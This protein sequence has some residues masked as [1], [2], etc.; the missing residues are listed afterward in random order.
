MRNTGETANWTE[1][2]YEWLDICLESLDSPTAPI[3]GIHSL[4]TDELL[5]RSPDDL[6]KLAVTIEAFTLICI[7]LRSRGVSANVWVG[8]PLEWPEENSGDRPFPPPTYEETRKSVASTLQMPEIFVRR[9]DPPSQHAHDD[10]SVVTTN[11][12]AALLN[13]NL[14]DARL[15]H[16]YWPEAEHHFLALD[17]QT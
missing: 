14:E 2:L 8:I 9:H 12:D 4:H 7:A 3:I 1:R 11:L 17:V 10:G 13:I 16:I 6:E 15:R 5:G